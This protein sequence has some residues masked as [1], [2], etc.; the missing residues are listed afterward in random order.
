MTGRT[1][2]SD[3]AATPKITQLTKPAP[4]RRVT[5]EGGPDLERSR[6]ADRSSRRHKDPKA[7][8]AG[9]TTRAAQTWVPGL[10]RKALD[11]K[12]KLNSAPTPTAARPA[13]QATGPV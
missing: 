4:K 8:A 7:T 11:G 9:A 1:S 13:D 3:A 2:P 12:P 10:S 6:V 5:L